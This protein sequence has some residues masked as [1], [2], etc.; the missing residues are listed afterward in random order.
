MREGPDDLLISWWLEF[1]T[2]E[3]RG[4]VRLLALCNGNM[5][6]VSWHILL[7]YEHV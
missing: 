7:S 4:T 2:S 1:H 6:I 3:T 5:V